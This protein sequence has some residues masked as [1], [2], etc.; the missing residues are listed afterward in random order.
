MVFIDGRDYIV[1]F[2]RMEFRCMVDFPRDGS[3]VAFESVEGRRLWSQLLV[4]TCERFGR[5]EVEPRSSSSVRWECGAW[6]VV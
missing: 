5:V 3:I 6:V 2:G 1:D 4:A